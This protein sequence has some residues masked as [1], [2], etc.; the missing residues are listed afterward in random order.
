[1]AVRSQIW[2]MQWSLGTIGR[3]FG[4]ALA[5][6]E[7][8]AVGFRGRCPAAAIGRPFGVVNSQKGFLT[9]LEVPNGR[10]RHNG[11]DRASL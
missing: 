1:M 9:W 8:F 2:A 4:V 5:G 7:H 3:E 11:R 6:R 10:N